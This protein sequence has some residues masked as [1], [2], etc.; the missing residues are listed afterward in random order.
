[1]SLA[2]AAS[3]AFLLAGLA[4]F[5]PYL[6]PN[7]V[8]SLSAD[9]DVVVD[10]EPAVPERQP[11]P[12]S[13]PRKRP[14][15]PEP[16]YGRQVALRADPR[17]HFLTEA[18]VN[19]RTIEMMVDTGATV[20]ALTSESARRLG[21]FLSASDYTI[22]MSTANGVVMAAPVTL[23]EIRIGGISVRNVTA[24]V[25]PGKVLGVN[26]LGMSFLQRL[27]KFELAGG[28]LVLVQ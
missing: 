24:T 13:E 10:E 27:S 20:V 6:A 18:T 19:G 1:M 8:A 7:V 22:P 28:K 4:V 15:D 11:L 5:V 3:A 16:V 17:G 21:L 23:S 14:P 26:L 12:L 2:R 9:R 25:M